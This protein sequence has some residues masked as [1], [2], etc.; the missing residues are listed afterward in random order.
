MP[1]KQLSFGSFAPHNNQQLFSDHYLDAILPQRPEWSTLVDGARPLMDAVRRIFESYTPSANEAQL[2]N[3]LV[4][5]LFLV[6]GHD[7]EVQPALKTPDGTKVPDYVFYVDAVARDANK[8]HILSDSLRR[9]G[10]IAVGDAKH[11]DRPLDLA[12]R[13]KDEDLF[14]NKNPSYQIAFYV[15]HSGV[16]WGILTNGRLWRLYHR[17]TAHKLDLYYEVDLPYL[18][19]NGDSESFLYFSLFFHRSAFDD[20]PV[21]LRSML[22]ESQDYAFAVGDSLKSQVYDALWH[23]AQG[24]L[25]YP[26]NRL[27]PEQETLSEIYDSSLILLYR[28]LFILYAEARELLPV[29]ESDMYRET[30][31]LH[32]IKGS[33][34]REI[35]SGRQILPT[36]A[37]I[38]PRLKELFTSIDK[39]NPP[40]KI[41]TFNGGLFDPGHYT[42]L[43]RYVVGDARLR[44]AIDGLARVKGHF[45]DYRDLAVRHLGAI[46][47][48]LLEYKIRPLKEPTP[49]GW[50]IELVNDK[51]ERKATGSYYTPDYIVK[52][53]VEEAVTPMLRR[54]ISGKTDDASKAAAVLEVNVLDPA[55]G[56]GHF[57]VE[58][59]ECIAR[60]LVDQA[61]TSDAAEYGETDL[62]H[63]KRRAAQSCIYGVDLNPLAVEL[64]KLALWLITVAKDRPLSFLDHHL[65]NGNALVGAHLSQLQLGAKKP[66]GRKTK[67]AKN[68]EAG[69]LSMM[70]DSAF[71]QSMSLAV[72]NM[73]LIEGMDARTVGDVKNQEKIYDELRNSFVNKYGRLADLITSTHFGVVVPADQWQP[74]ADYATG[75]MLVGLP[76]FIKTIEQVKIEASSHRFFHWEL[77]FPEVFFD[78]FGRSLNDMAGFDAVVGNPPYIR[79]EKLAEFKPFF[80]TAFASFNS[81]ADLYLYFYEQGLKLL[82]ANGRMA[83]ISSGTF[84]RSNFAVA[85]RKW[86]PTVARVDSVIDFGENQPFDGAE[87]VRPS[88]MVLRKDLDERPFSSLF[89]HGGV[90]DSLELAL[91]E[92]GVDCSPSTLTRS[93][94]VFQTNG[95]GVLLKRLFAAGKPL[96]TIADGNICYGV[97]TGLNDAFIITSDQRNALIAEDASSAHIIKPLVQGKD[98]RPWYWEEAERWLIFTRRGVD[99]DAYPAVKRHLDAFRERLLP[100][101]K[102]WPK[103]SAWNGRKSGHYEWF[104]IQD[105]V[106]YYEAFEAQKIFWPDIAKLPRFSWGDPELYIGNTGYAIPNA[107]PYLLG[108]LQSRVFWY[109]VSQVCQPLRL[110]GGLWQYR[111][112]PQYISRL[113]I[114]EA[115][116][117]DRQA[118]GDLAMQITRPAKTRYALHQRV[119]ARLIAD[120]GILGVNLSNRLIAWWTLDIMSLRS[121]LR[122]VF[123]KDIPVRERDEWAEWLRENQAQHQGLT[124]EIIALEMDLNNRVYALFDL[125]AAE[126]KL[127]EESTKYKYGEV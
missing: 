98:L 113:P 58:T 85:F 15:Q 88:I 121:E 104:E 35:T 75:K 97:K 38:W 23:I 96:R 109:T 112:L 64:A 106:D 111:V 107:E 55:M 89:L 19:E 56:S 43:D 72:G 70:A 91:V 31:G 14:N 123:K 78:R 71:V 124:N 3:D 4:R 115:G 24:F 80:K 116:S 82:Q 100:K 27:R 105:T 122:R 2:E 39:G 118:V 54:S 22:R 66:N 90:P 74:L 119:R 103:K 47:E 52:Y 93:E 20:Q 65:R 61:V 83:Y 76:A 99:I 13:S 6:L 101:P 34:A 114:P 110:R 86:L 73:W 50:T 81:V 102:N 16:D 69:Q 28:L 41:A 62:L 44:L 10:G 51:G 79:Q 1:P 37:T 30:Y 95:T 42:F 8:N 125:N 26:P 84:A 33:V 29:R 57:L 12:S 60:F 25:D 21:G 18:L 77:E 11:W 49:D 68:E 108:I 36:S 46:Y 7:F 9:Q 45:I 5:P 59:T 120:F 53:I 127:I 117:E 87:M 63:W 94:W 32:A 92:E 48:G 126:Q 17:D 40:L 67:E